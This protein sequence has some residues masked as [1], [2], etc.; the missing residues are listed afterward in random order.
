[1]TLSS[2]LFLG[3]ILYYFFVAISKVYIIV[4]N[5][6]LSFWWWFYFYVSALGFVSFKGPSFYSFKDSFTVFLDISMY[7][8]PVFQVVQFL[9]VF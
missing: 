8:F 2:L 7:Y 3:L 6:Y 4:V 1:M 9:H 5:M